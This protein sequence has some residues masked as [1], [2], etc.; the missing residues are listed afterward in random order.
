MKRKILCLPIILAGTMAC[1]QMENSKTIENN[2]KQI[3][4]VQF[5]AIHAKYKE[6]SLAHRRFKHADIDALVQMKKQN[7]ILDV[8][9]VG[10]SVEGRVIY[11]LEYGQGHKQ[12]MLWSQM[13]G[14]EPTATMAL[15]DIFNFLE[16]SEDG[17]DSLRSLIKD[18]LHL[19]FIPMLNP[20][21]AERYTRRNAQSI[22]LNR[23]ARA[24]QTVEGKLLK[25]RAK[26]IQ[27]KYGFNLH[28]QNIYYNVPNTKN[29]VTI[30]LLAPAYNYEREVNEV[31]KG[32]MQIIV[33]MNEVLQQYVPQAVAKYD[34]AH[35]PRGFG[36]NF[37]GWG[38]STVLIESGGLKGDP[39]K[40]E[41]RKLNF[42]I[43]LNALLQI[44]QD[45]YK[46]YDAQSYE[47]I[48]FNASQL[49]DVVI[50]NIAVETESVPLLTDLAVRRSEFT[51][52]SDYYVRGRVE[53][54]GDLQESFGYDEIDVKGMNFIP[55][56]VSPN[57]VT[58]V[59]SLSQEEIYELLKKG[60]C[61]VRV[62]ERGAE[63]AD[64]LHNLPIHVFSK[65][66]FYPTTKLALGGTANFFIGK[67]DE[68][69][70][71]VLNGYLIDL[72]RPSEG[73]YKNRIH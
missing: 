44:S 60:F 27:P 21:G 42:I 23:D 53:D 59:A 71:A 58:S 14:D 35:T 52:G 47:D 34:D 45:S 66:N 43:I 36:D 6:G 65:Q 73:V 55:G 22:D 68:I 28:D 30:S 8:K 37:Q 39:E 63:E 25:E 69:R 1:S 67:G 7:R 51:V 46:Q 3:D 24:G 2:A 4:T 9:K 12:V 62:I 31:R 49:H 56:K 64:A 38:A 48:P 18:N 20:D 13:H 32:A 29:P 40:Q 19:H 61:A 10:E 72:E 26:E 54:I 15:F 33:G 11:E 41:I 5:N 57:A 17:Y 50:R 16:G 70:Y